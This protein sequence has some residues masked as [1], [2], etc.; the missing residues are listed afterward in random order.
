MTFIVKPG[1][2]NKRVEIQSPTSTNNSFGE[3][4]RSWTTVFTRWAS[5]I[6]LSSSERLVAAQAQAT[7]THEM[8]LRDVTGIQANW[9]IKFDGR[10]FNING[11][12]DKEE[13]GSLRVLTLTEVTIT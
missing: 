6:P 2:L 1:K 11:I 12:I 13:R 4:T 3:S 7:I 10:I 5:V 9:R 8:R